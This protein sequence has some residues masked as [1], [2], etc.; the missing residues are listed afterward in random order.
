MDPIWTPFMP[1]LPKTHTEI[2]AIQAP[3]RS[4]VDYGG[5]GT[6]SGLML[7]VSPAET[8][9]WYVRYYT[10]AGNGGL[11]RRRYR[12]GRFPRMGLAAARKV[13]RALLAQV[14]GDADPSQERVDN[15]ARAKGT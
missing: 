14:D 5:T 12:L 15:K 6:D 3:E 11:K 1:D 13:A 4:R 2:R 9:T 10:R 7:R 8:K